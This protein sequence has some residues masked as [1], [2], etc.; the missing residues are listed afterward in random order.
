MKTGILLKVKMMKKI[1]NKIKNIKPRTK[2]LIIILLVISQLL[3]AINILCFGKINPYITEQNVVY[4]PTKL[5]SRFH[6]TIISIDEFQYWV[7]RLNNKE[8]QIII[9][10]AENGGNWTKMTDEH[11]DKLDSFDSYIKIFGYFYRYHD[12]YISIYD[13][14]NGEIIT[15]SENLI[16]LDTTEWIVFLYDTDTNKYCCVFQTA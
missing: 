3:I 5:P 10:E 9:N 12:C 6:Y 15:N 13:A 14:Q 7:F 2:K 4:T 11:V 1:V 8:E 16:Y